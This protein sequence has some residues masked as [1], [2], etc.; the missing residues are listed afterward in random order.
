MFYR[1]YDPA[2]G[3]MLQVDPFAVMYA[4]STTYNYGLNNPV[5]FN[6]PS[7]GRAVAPAG[8]SVS[9]WNRIQRLNNANDPHYTQNFVDGWHES[10]GGGMF[11]D[12]W[13]VKNGSMSLWDYARKYGASY[14]GGE[15]G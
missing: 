9:A 4:S 8:V 14:G 2:L 7:G 6:D 1:G 11:D 3:R 13:S 12:A 10:Y 15:N 5:A